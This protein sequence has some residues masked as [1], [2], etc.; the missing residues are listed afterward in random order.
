MGQAIQIDARGVGAIP[1]TIAAGQSLSLEIDTQGFPLAGLSVPSNYT[2]TTITAQA[3][4]KPGGSFQD[5]R[6]ATGAEVVITVAAN[7]IVALGA[8]STLALLRFL[9][10]RSGTAASPTV[11]GSSVRLLLLRKQGA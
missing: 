6:D 11:Q 10:L 9:K 7:R 1:V 2:G 5:V 8:G 4:Q 3:A